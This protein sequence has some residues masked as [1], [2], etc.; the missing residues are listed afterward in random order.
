[1]LREQKKNFY[2]S[3]KELTHCGNGNLAYGGTM[4]RGLQFFCTM[5]YFLT[6]HVIDYNISRK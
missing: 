5:F 2:F 1:M 4:G 6:L 3:L